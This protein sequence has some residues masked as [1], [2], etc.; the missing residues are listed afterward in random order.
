[1]TPTRHIYIKYTP[2]WWWQQEAERVLSTSGT[3]LDENALIRDALKAHF[4]SW[5]AKDLA[6]NSIRGF[7][8]EISNPH[9]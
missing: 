4:D 1:M 2:P 7:E 5:M 9:L 8:T 6:D 3:A